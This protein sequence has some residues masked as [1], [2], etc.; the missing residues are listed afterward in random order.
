MGR[1]ASG[2]V[3]SWAVLQRLNHFE[4]FPIPVPLILYIHDPSAPISQHPPW[5]VLFLPPARIL[6]Q[7]TLAALSHLVTTLPCAA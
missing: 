5:R 7:A 3:S 1:I 2:R 6:K 4:S